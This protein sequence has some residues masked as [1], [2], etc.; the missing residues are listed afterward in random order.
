M[1]KNLSKFKSKCLNFFPMTNFRLSK[2][3]EFAD[4]NFKFDKMADSSP[5]G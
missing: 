5:N 1:V 3:K 2:L 4:N